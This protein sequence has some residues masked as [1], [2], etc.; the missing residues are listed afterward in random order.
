MGML[1]LILAFVVAIDHYRIFI[2]PDADGMTQDYLNFLKLGLDA[3]HA[4]MLFFLISGFLI[5]YALENKYLGRQGGV[6]RYFESRFIRIYPFF[7]FMSALALIV[8]LG[9]TH[10]ATILERTWGLVLYG[11]DWRLITGGA[12]LYPPW[13]GQAWTLASEVTY[14][15]LAPLLFWSVRVFWIA[16]VLALLTRIVLLK[17]FGFDVVWTYQFSG[18]TLIFFLFGHFGRIC[19]ARFTQPLGRLNLAFG[20]ASVVFLLLNVGKSFDNRYFSL[21]VVSLALFL[22]Y[23]FEKTKDSP[24]LNFLGDNTYT[25]YLSHTAVIFFLYFASYAPFSAYSASM[26]G[27]AFVSIATPAG[28]LLNTVV[29]LLVCMLASIALHLLVERPLAAFTRLVFARARDWGTRGAVARLP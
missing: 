9:G 4:V 12:Q 27:L 20:V 11:N 15:A 17:M 25:L 3:G 2:L 24:T 21:C 10:Q 16:F 19:Y 8:I 23:L 7:W 6:I 29:F 18:S 5:S 13:L 1:R 14:Y 28:L 22:P 26:K